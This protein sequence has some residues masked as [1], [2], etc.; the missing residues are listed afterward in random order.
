MIFISKKKRIKLGKLIAATKHMAIHS[1]G[2][3]DKKTQI[4]NMSKIV[5][6]LADMAFEIG[7]EKF[8]MIDVVAEEYSLQEALKKRNEVM[9]NH[10]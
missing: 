8:A 6:N 5:G 10:E 9:N 1:I 4:E 2:E 7:G 3:T